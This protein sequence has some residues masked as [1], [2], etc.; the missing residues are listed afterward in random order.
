MRES[1]E[2]DGDEGDGPLLFGRVL[3]GKGGA[4]QIGWDEVQ[5]WEPQTPHEVLWIHLW[6]IRPGVTQWL[7]S[8]LGLPEPTA[9][10]LTSDDTRP[11]A[12]REGGA[13]VATLRAINVNPGADPED[14][15][16]MQMWCD[17]TRLVTLRRHRLQAP[18]ETLAVVDG[19][20]G[21][22]DAGAVITLLIEY[23]IAGMGGSIVDI[24]DQIDELEQIYTDQDAATMLDRIVAI[25]RS[26]LALKRHMSPQ[27][28]AMEQI[29]RDAPDWF[30]DHDRREIAE[31]IHRMRRYLDDLDISKESVLVMQD[32]MRARA[33]AS[34]NRTSYLLTIVASIFLPLTFITGLLGIN[35]GGIPGAEDAA[36]FWTV[37]GLCGAIMVIQLA[38]FRRWKWF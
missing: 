7:E 27:H 9:R 14:M 12:L 26:C 10:L 5:H 6:R 30:E 2:Y 33:V 37:V 17:G 1:D 21:P 31:T 36:A 16:S 29:A 13:L 24:N 19:G 20:D 38:L 8:G 32:D 4:R 11:R 15:V 23:M 35:V 28:E 18:R 3:D 25:R 34:T 22:A